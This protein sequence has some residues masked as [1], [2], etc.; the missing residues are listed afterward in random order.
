MSKN[1]NE[2]N[3]AQSA[4]TNF[5]LAAAIAAGAYAGMEAYGYGRTKIRRIKENRRNR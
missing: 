2:K 3:L 1:E 5:V 4:A